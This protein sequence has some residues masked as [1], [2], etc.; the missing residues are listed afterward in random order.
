[1]LLLSARWSEHISDLLS[2]GAASAP[3]STGIGG[4]VITAS[5]TILS[6]SIASRVARISLIL[7]EAGELEDFGAGAL[8]I[9]IERAEFIDTRW[10]IVFDLLILQ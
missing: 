3:T 4:L 8:V 6:A 1:M 2:K 7:V 9:W 10:L 5:C